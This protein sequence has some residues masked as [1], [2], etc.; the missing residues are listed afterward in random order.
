[1]PYIEKISVPYDMVIFSDSILGRNDFHYGC[2]KTLI[3][4]D[5]KILD[6]FR[7][8]QKCNPQIPKND[9]VSFLGSVFGS[10]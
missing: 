2:L 7:I 8:S 10:C 3:N 5:F 9:I 4:G 6:D 1:M